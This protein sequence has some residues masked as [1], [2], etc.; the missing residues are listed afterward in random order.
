MLID[1]IQL[2]TF[3][4]VAEERHL[5]HAAERLH[6]SRSSASTHI[7]AIE[8]RLGMQLFVRTNRSLSLTRAGEL[9]LQQAKPLIDQS[10]R[11]AAFARKLQGRIDGTLVL[12]ANSEPSSSRVGEIV[13]V[14]RERHPL[15]C[16]DMRA[17]HSAG[18]LQGLKTGEIDAGL[19]SGEPRDPSFIYYPLTGLRFRIAGPSAW[20]DRIHQAGWEEL[21]AMPWVIS[22]DDTLAYSSW[23]N[24][25]FADRGLW[26]NSVVRFD[27][28]TLARTLP[29]TGVGLMLLREE[30]A[31]QGEREGT[32]ALSPLGLAEFPLQA[33]HLTSRS[34]DPLVKAFVE[35]VA[36]VWPSARARHA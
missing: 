10:V 11:F 14:I 15:V 28:G 23:L 24:R 19:V 27:N 17:R 22:S 20:R 36:V 2:R 13:A 33:V 1:L 3:V 16:V 7:R 32:L 9:L 21:A 6:I 4:A 18:T 12:G 35:A 29:A 34:K 25:Q 31:L 26:L 8:Q 5:T 30:Y